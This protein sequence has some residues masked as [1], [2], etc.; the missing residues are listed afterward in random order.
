MKAR[1]RTKCPSIAISTNGAQLGAS[2]ATGLFDEVYTAW[3][4]RVLRWVRLLGASPADYEDLAQ[5]VFV[6][7]HR[8]LCEFDGRNVGGWLYQMARWKVRDYHELSHMKLL[9]GDRRRSAVRRVVRGRERN[10]QRSTR[11]ARGSRTRSAPIGRLGHAGRSQA[12]RV[13]AVRS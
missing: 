2:H 10:R 9:A 3:Y 12:Q 5:E 4:G 8:Q 1:P 7:A 6:I 11:S 13:R